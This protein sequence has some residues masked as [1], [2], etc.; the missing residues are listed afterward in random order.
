MER[1]IGHKV[2]DNEFNE[3]NTKVCMQNKKIIGLYFAGSYC[4]SC[5]K[6]T[7]IL[8]EVYSKIKEINPNFEI[9]FISDDKT[10]ESFN[11]YLK[12]MPWVAIPYEQKNIKSKLYNMFEIKSIPHLILINEDGDIINSNGR[13]YIY[14][15][16]NNICQIIA[17]LKLG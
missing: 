3:I 9:V 4:S 7:P 15:N 13:Y 6:F 5:I 16:R 17:D 14:N 11:H 1:L 8:N 12:Y 10:I 2:I